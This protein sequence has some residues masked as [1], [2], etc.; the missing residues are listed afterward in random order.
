ME[1]ALASFAAGAAAA[2]GTVVIIDVFRAFTTAAVALSRGATR[3]IMVASLEE[4]LALRAAGAGDL[5]VGERHGA[6]P[7]GFDFGNSPTEMAAAELA[8]KTLILTTTNGT[9][10]IAAAGRATRLYAAAFVTAEATLRALRA[11]EPARVTLVAM[12][13]KGE[14]RAD[15][16]ELFA[17]YLRSRLEGRAPDKDAMR[18]LLMTMPPPPDPGLV[19][20][21]E[22]DPRDR[23][24][25]A[26]IDR[27]D[28][29]I[30]V[31]SENGCFSATAE[32]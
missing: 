9:A 32:H 27:V 17:F 13:R 26:E 28:F 8:G 11:A 19:A 10:G 24:I 6:R 16:D 20:Q 1:I 7:E 25:A 30:R 4:A 22:Y 21:G 12:G 15:E 31:R 5:C 29:A 14:R 18:R 23:T 2:T 3:I